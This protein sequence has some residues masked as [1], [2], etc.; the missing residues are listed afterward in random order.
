[1]TTSIN[2]AYC[3]RHA[4][5]FKP[6]AHDLEKLMDMATKGLSPEEREQRLR[7]LS[8]FMAAIFEVYVRRGAAS[9]ITVFLMTIDTKDDMF[10]FALS[11]VFNKES[12]CKDELLAECA[13]RPGIKLS[14]KKLDAKLLK[15]GRDIDK[16]MKSG[17]R[18]NKIVEQAFKYKPR[19]H[20]TH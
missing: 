5:T 17:K 13:K 12:P 19:P 16:L 14:G 18:L 9:A 20:T 3:Q 7:T 11:M 6:L 1:M 8:K 4:R 2:S 10:V 15:F